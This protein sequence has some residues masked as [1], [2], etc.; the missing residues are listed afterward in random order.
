MVTV[1]DRVRVLAP[2]D[3]TYSDT[4]T[5]IAIDTADDGQTTVLLA[6]IESAFSPEYLEAV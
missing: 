3:E 5:V 6:G 1:G 4:A 2:F